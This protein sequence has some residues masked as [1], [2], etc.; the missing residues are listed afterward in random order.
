M[1]TIRIKIIPTYLFWA[2]NT[3]IEFGYCDAM[4]RWNLK[5]KDMQVTDN[6]PETDD[7]GKPSKKK[8]IKDINIILIHNIIS[9]YKFIKNKI[10]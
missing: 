4:I 2:I 9:A 8:Y 6:E 3:N 7:K 1:E 10:I 5:L